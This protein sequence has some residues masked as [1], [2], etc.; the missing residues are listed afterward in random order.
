ME[1]SHGTL[2]DVAF[3]GTWMIEKSP[4]HMTLQ[5]K[6]SILSRNIHKVKMVH[7][8]KPN[9]D[10]RYILYQRNCGLANPNSGRYFE[11]FMSIFKL[12][13]ADWIE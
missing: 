4:V 10:G 1:E 12:H 6:G 2:L 11:I 8:R 7:S 5:K 3:D 13:T 9:F